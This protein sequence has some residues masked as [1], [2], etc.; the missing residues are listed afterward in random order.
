MPVVDAVVQ[1]EVMDSAWSPDGASM[2]YL[3]YTAAPGLGSGDANQLWLKSGAD[4]PHPLTPLIPLFGR[5]GSLTHQLPPP[6]FPHLNNLLLVP[7]SPDPP[8]PSSAH[9]PHPP[10]RPT[11]PGNVACV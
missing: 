3:L 11:P 10:A 9:H 8:P 1:G 7:T 2:A 6:L 5:G 4:Q